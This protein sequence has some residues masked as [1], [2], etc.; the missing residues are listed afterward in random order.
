[1]EITQTINVRRID[2]NG[3]KCTYHASE[4]EILKGCF[5]ICKSDAGVIDCLHRFCFLVLGRI[6]AINV[7]D[8]EMPNKQF[9]F[10]FPAAFFFFFCQRGKKEQRIQNVIRPQEACLGGNSNGSG[11]FLILFAANKRIKMLYKV[12][13][14]LCL[15]QW[16]VPGSGNRRH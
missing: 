6:T 5:A 7:I 12:M 2:I 16:F 1:M 11:T 8:S 10:S 9:S 3:V 15:V 4:K 14:M 13:S